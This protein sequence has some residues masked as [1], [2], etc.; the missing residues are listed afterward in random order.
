MDN[1]NEADAAP[2]RRFRKRWILWGFVGLWSAVGLWNTVRPMPPGT[3][4]RTAP[5]A[6]DPASVQF[7]T[8]LTW[9]DP[10]GQSLREQRIFDEVLRIVDEAET[11]IVADFF[12]FNDLMGAA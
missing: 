5:V 4:V 6:L 2:R 1:N 9:N 7:L 11:F 8:D 10:R 3:D 12:L